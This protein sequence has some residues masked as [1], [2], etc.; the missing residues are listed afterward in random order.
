MLEISGPSALHGVFLST[1]HH[2]VSPSARSECRVIT[3]R[4]RRVDVAI[5]SASAYTPLSGRHLATCSVV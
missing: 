4:Q 2:R 1:A 5:A 3:R